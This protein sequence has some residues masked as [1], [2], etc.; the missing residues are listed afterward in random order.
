[1]KKMAAV[2]EFGTRMKVKVVK[3]CWKKVKSNR[4]LLEVVATFADKSG[5]FT[6]IE[7]R[8]RRFIAAIFFLFFIFTFIFFLFSIFI[9]PTRKGG[10]TEER[11]NKGA[12]KGPHTDLKRLQSI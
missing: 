12:P 2:Y 11:T 1:M 8:E 10:R 9:T 6:L 3:W 7:V 4:N 5:Q